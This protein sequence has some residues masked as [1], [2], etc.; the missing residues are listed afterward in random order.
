MTTF[1]K[2][3]HFSVISGLKTKEHT[4]F[5]IIIESF[6]F[7]EIIKVIKSKQNPNLPLNQVPKSLI[8]MSFK[9]LQDNKMS[10]SIIAVF[11]NAHNNIRILI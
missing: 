2:L 8:N 9:H 11:Q 10:S 1:G 5:G 4:S 7:K 6:W 3:F